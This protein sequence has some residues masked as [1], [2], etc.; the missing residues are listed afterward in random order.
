MY[1]K[2]TA[3]SCSVYSCIYPKFYRTMKLIMVF[4][5]AAI[6]QVSAVSYAQQISLQTNGEAMESVFISIKQQSGYDF[7]YSA[8]LLKRIKPVSIK[9]RNASITQVMDK[10]LA[11]QPLTYII[12]GKTI[13]LKAKLNQD[14]DVKGRVVD[15]DGKS[16]QG[17]NIRVKDRLIG[18][19]ISGADGDFSIKV[20]GAKSVLIFSFLGFVTQEVTVGTKNS[21][22][23]VLQEQQNDLSEVVVTALGIKRGRKIIRLCNY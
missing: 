8:D 9:I 22:V 6:I 15:K 1:K 16:I 20:S 23:V 3:F 10:L 11:D 12:N 7:L 5:F 14:I 19:V 2:N 17:V 13:T 4:V 18:G 21:L